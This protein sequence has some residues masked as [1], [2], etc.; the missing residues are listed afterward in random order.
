MRNR[1]SPGRIGELESRIRS[2]IV[3]I[4]ERDPRIWRSRRMDFLSG[5]VVVNKVLMSIRVLF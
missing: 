2:R 1:F 4:S 5:P 3:V